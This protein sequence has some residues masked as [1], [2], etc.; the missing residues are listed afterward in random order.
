MRRIELLII[1]IICLLIIAI[2]FLRLITPED[3]WIC[4][5]GQWVKHGQ[6]EAPMP[7]GGCER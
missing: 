5:D 6:P 1:S 2:L 7:E 4:A 3:N